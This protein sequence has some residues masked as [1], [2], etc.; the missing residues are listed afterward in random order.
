MNPLA[1]VVCGIFAV[2]HWHSP[3]EAVA[4]FLYLMALAEAS[5][6][7]LATRTIR[8]E[9]NLAIAILGGV[10][11]VLST[12]WPKLLL[13][14]AGVGVLERLAGAVALGAPL[15]VANVATRSAAFGGGDVKLLAASGLVLGLRVGVIALG[16][17]IL[18]GGLYA[19]YLKYVRHEPGSATFALG[20]WLAIGCA[21]AYAFGPTLLPFVW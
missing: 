5:R 17:G 21:A 10:T 9:L 14:V 13:P 15:L 4:G 16:S 2:W 1:A 8:N 12:L 7:D 19:C 6:T 3:F 11:A 18:L 20:P